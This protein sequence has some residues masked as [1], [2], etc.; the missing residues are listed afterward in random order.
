M[1]CIVLIPVSL[2]FLYGFCYH[3]KQILIGKKIIKSEKYT[4][5]KELKKIFSLGLVLLILEILIFVAF[6]KVILS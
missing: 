2:F 6:I 1:N 3:I 5:E 4:D